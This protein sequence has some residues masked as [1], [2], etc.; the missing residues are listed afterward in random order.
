MYNF[1]KSPAH[2]WLYPYTGKIIRPTDQNETYGAIRDLEGY[3][4]VRILH[5]QLRFSRMASDAQGERSVFTAGT[6]EQPRFR[7]QTPIYLQDVE[8]SDEI[9]ISLGSELFSYNITSIA[10]SLGRMGMDGM[11]WAGGY[12]IFQ[13]RLK[14][15]PNSHLD[16]YVQ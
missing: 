10:P 4:H 6:V 14:A 11:L 2:P 13:A 15:V 1:L 9:V 5:D 7:F 3:R 12:T 16:I 8:T